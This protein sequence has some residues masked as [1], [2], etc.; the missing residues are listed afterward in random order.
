MR[1]RRHISGKKP[2]LG[3]RFDVHVGLLLQDESAQGEWVCAQ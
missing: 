3:I 1:I 2:D